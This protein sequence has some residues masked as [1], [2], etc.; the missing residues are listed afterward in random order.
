MP[1]FEPEARQDPGAGQGRVSFIRATSLF[2]G[3][4]EDEVR[5]LAE[6]MSE[7]VIG[8]GEVLFN[9]GERGDR[10]Y[11]IVDGCVEVIKALGTADE[12]L[13]NALMPGAFFGEMSLLD[14]AGLRTASVRARTA[15]RLLS[16]GREDFDAL[17]RGYPALAYEI[18][19]VLTLKLRDANDA[20]ISDLR[21]KNEELSRAYAELEAAQEQIIA[22]EKLEQELKMA[23][24]I[25]QSILPP[26]PPALAGCDV[27]V[28]ML[29]ARTVG[30]DLYDFIPLGKGRLGIAIGDVSD[31]GVPAAIFMALTSS[32]LRAA[33]T[34][35]TSPRRV[36]ERVNSILLGMNAA[37]MFVTLLYGILDPAAALFT[38][39]RAGHE[40]PLLFDHCGKPV[41]APLGRSTPLGL[42]ERPPIDEQ[43]I[44]FPANSSIVLYT[45]GVTDVVNAGGELFGSD[46]LHQAAADVACADASQA[47]CDSVWAR[48]EDHQGGAVQADDVTLVVVRNA[49]VPGGFR[50]ADAL[51]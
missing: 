6:S 22:K 9:E 5:P 32:I 35:S 40:L 26:R 2:G 30:G 45:D 27:A 19:R 8:A 15:T 13:L 21:R 10:L 4:G 34:R 17:L 7:N 16:I 23:A 28:R 37:G 42:F 12:R 20:T 36:L 43:A 1:A 24:W 47:M 39:A 3:L 14:P 49:G 41:S 48:L 11:L 44:A 50:A 38:Y 18:V 33:A 31:K 51:H 25:Q 29:P 46:R